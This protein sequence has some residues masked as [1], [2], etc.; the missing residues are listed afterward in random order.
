MDRCPVCN[1]HIDGEHVCFNCYFDIT[2]CENTRRLVVDK[3]S[4]PE[5]LKKSHDA[6][7][8]VVRVHRNK[9]L[10]T[11]REFEFD[12]SFT[13][14]VKYKGPSSTVIVPYGVEAIEGAFSEN[15][16]IRKVVLPDTVTTIGRDAFS[17]CRN[18]ESVHIP[19]KTTHIEK[20][21]FWGCK[22]LDVVIPKNISVIEEGAFAQ[23]KS[24]C[25]SGDNAQFIIHQD[26]LIDVRRGVLLAAAFQTA[27]MEIIVPEGVKRIGT[28]A[29]NITRNL[30]ASITLP[31]SLVS[32][33][34]GALVNVAKM[35]VLIP[36]SVSRIE[37]DAF[38]MRSE[39]KL[40]EGNPNYFQKNN[41]IIEIGTS[42]LLSVC[43]KK[44][45]TVLIP[46][47]IKTIA[48]RAFMYCQHM[49]EISI[50]RSVGSI[51][52][53]AFSGCESLR[54]IVIPRSVIQMGHAVFDGCFSLQTVFCEHEST[55][56]GWLETW[57]KGC[58]ACIDGCTGSNRKSF[59][60]TSA[61]SIDK[62]DGHD[63][64]YFCA[65]LLRKN[66]FSDVKVTKGSGDQGVDILAK[67]DGIKY[68]IQCKNY[69]SHLG[70]TPVQ[71]VNAGKFF[72][73]CHVGVV[74]TNS[75]FTQGA[76]ALAQATGVLL[77]D[78]AVLT[79]MMEQIN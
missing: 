3:S 42:K 17:F 44:C 63:F 1:E 53:Y 25:V 14:I 12:I 79:R 46:P 65:E 22:N 36:K 61:L 76:K 26:I 18:L 49:A 66:G 32:I 73:N 13:K 70:N 57:S 20:D 60:R 5:A 4:D 78:R 74:I 56:S 52:H 38:A 62:M 11:L 16:T 27:G 50:P 71:E 24:I 51:G 58:K 8:A 2:A 75:T 10:R 67:K 39:V 47:G 77:W 64:E 33:G 28:R 48:D 55:P 54:S 69:A 21:A 30:P 19:D 37:N 41:L 43:N 23:V 7:N 59:N 72:Y 40:E 35:P 45:D 29:F 68:A 9:W 15:Q 6:I 34:E 31:R